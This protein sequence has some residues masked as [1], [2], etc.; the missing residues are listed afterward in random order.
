MATLRYRSMSASFPGPSPD[1]RADAA[2]CDTEA[3]NI[4]KHH[5]YHQGSWGR[6]WCKGEWAEAA[7]QSVRLK[8]MDCLPF[9]RVTC[10]G[11]VFGSAYFA[12]ILTYCAGDCLTGAPICFSA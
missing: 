7:A 5:R 10:N 9:S 3:A 8:S 11:E 2:A 12:G 4:G 1:V 6:R